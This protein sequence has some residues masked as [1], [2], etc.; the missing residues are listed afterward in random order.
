MADY[1]PRIGQ[2]GGAK[3]LTEKLKKLREAPVSKEVIRILEEGSRIKK[4]KPRKIA[5]Q[6]DLDG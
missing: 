6:K 2:K 4:E 1:K 3:R 5:N